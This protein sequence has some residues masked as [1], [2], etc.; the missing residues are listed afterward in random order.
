MMVQSGKAVV[1]LGDVRPELVRN[2][3]TMTIIPQNQGRIHNGQVVRSKGGSLYPS[4]GELGI[5]GVGSNR[6]QP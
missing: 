6:M 5:F 4:P 3:A 2:S 1:K